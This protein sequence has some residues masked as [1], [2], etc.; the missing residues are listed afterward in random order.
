MQLL[1]RPALA[2]HGP[3]AR[4]HHALAN[5]RAAF[6][7]G[8]LQQ[9]LRWQRGHVDVQI[10]AVQQRA[11]QLALVTAN[12]LRAAATRPLG[13]AMKA[14]GAG[15]HR[16]QQLKAGRKLAAQGRAGNGDVAV[17]QRLAQRFQGAAG[18]FRKLI[19]KQ[20]AMVGQ[21]NGPRP[22]RGAPAH[23]RHRAGGVVRGAG[24]A[25]A[26]FLRVK[27][28]GQAGHG[29]ALQRLLLGH[30][31]QQAAK[32]LGQHGFTG[33]R[34]PHQ[35][36]AVPAS[37]GNLQGAFGL[38]LALHIG[39]IGAAGAV[40]GGLRGDALPAF[41]AGLAQQMRHHIEQ[42]RRTKHLG[43]GGQSG[44]A[45]T[46][47]GQNQALI[48]AVQAAD[49]AAA[50]RAQGTREGQLPGKLPAVQSLQRNLPAGGQNPQRNRQVKAARIL[51]QVGRGQID[52]DAL[53]VGKLQPAVLQSA[54]H[55]LAG[56]FHLHI[57]QPHQT[58]AGQAIGQM[59]FHRHRRGGQSQQGTALNTRKGHGP[60]FSVQKWP[61]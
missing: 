4:L 9:L 13:A 6:P 48:A 24:G 39:Q 42:M 43:G 17:F 49:Q 32:A 61:I 2:G 28:P 29:G 30:G 37:G 47:Q 10:N 60:P 1:V 3:L 46:V 27:A 52:G 57:G 15:I 26:P 55:A 44:F 20:H 33:P 35:Q 18:K 7:G 45:G 16:R 23:Q 25:Q 58:Q 51:G 8:R 14:T 21:R 5:G 31:G 22:G 41:A 53:V 56:L 54:A 11:A 38:H 59:D 50:H 34:W 36:Q 40:D 19:Q 12:L